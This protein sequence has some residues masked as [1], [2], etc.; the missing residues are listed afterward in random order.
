MSDYSLV[1]LLTLI[2]FLALAV[3]L[4]APVYFFLNREEERS[5][6]WT[7]DVLSERAKRP[8]PNSNGSDGAPEPPR[9]DG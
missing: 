4:L 5:E 9:S 3:L 7:R 2:G 8:P 6:R 1:I